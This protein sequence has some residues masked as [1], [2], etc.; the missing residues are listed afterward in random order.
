MLLDSN[1]G[2]SQNSSS[3][4]FF[5]EGFMVLIIHCSD[6]P[7]KIVYQCMSFSSMKERKNKLV[8]KKRKKTRQKK[9][10][11]MNHYVFTNST[12]RE[13]ATLP[14]WWS[15]MVQWLALLTRMKTGRRR[16]NARSRHLTI[17]S[18]KCIYSKKNCESQNNYSSK[19]S[20]H[21]WIQKTWIKNITLG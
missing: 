19:Q 7:I 2:F 14:A 5:K 4:F 9:I 18:D 13:N 12:N 8:R 6:F 20:L 1:P 21:G 10:G 16:F 3:N 11:P 17:F 15:L